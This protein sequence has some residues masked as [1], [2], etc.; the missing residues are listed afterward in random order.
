MYADISIPRS[1]CGAFWTGAAASHAADRSGRSCRRPQ[2]RYT[3]VFF[4]FPSIVCVIVIVIVII[5]FF[6]HRVLADGPQKIA[7]DPNTGRSCGW[8]RS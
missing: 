3:L 6:D 2:L 8:S 4:T 7:S 1:T 5:V